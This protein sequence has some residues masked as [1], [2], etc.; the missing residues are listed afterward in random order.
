[1]SESTPP[2][3]PP[4]RRRVRWRKVVLWGLVLVLSLGAGVLGFAYAY[5]TDGEGLALLIRAEAPRYLPGAL[6]EVGQ[7][8]L[9]P[10]LGEVTLE[11]VRLKQK[12][13][14]G[15]VVST[16]QV[17]WLSV[18]HDLAALTRGELVPREVV[19]VKPVLRLCRRPDGRWNLDGLLADPW[20][21]PPLESTPALHVRDGTIELLENPGDA[22]PAMVLRDVSLHAKPGTA[23]EPIAVE[24]TARGGP[25]EQVRFEGTF[26]LEN[27]RVVLDR[28]DLTRLVL[29]ENLIRC[30]PDDAM[31]EAVRG[32]GLSGGELD[33]TLDH[34]TYDPK[35]RDP[36][37]YAAEVRLRGGTLQ[38][39]D[40]PFALSGVE[41]VAAIRDDTVR[42]L[43]AEARYGKTLFSASG[44]A[45][46]LDPK[47]GPLDLTLTATNLELDER[48][49]A[50]TPAEYR[51]LWDEYRP[52][53]TVDAAARV[54]RRDPGGPIGF[55]ASVNLRDVGIVYAKFQY[56]LQHIRGTLVWEGPT[57][58]LDVETIVGGEPLTGKGT[59]RDPGDDAVV[60]I[61]FHAGSMPVD[62]ALISAMPP[63]VAQV[64]R[65]FEPQ[66]SVR[67]VVHIQR[68]PP[69]SPE[70]HPKADPDGIYMHAELDLNPGSSVRWIG[71][72]Y[73]V[74]SVTGHLDLKPDRWAFQGMKG[75][76]GT[77]TLEADGEVIVV[78][79]DVEP[80]VNLRIKA[81]RLMFDQQLRDALPPEWQQ[82][83]AT[84]NPYGRCRVEASI[85]TGP[86][87]LPHYRMTVVPE[88]TETRVKLVLTPVLIG[89]DGEPTM[90]TLI[91]LPV[92]EN[93]SGTFTF[94]DGTVTMADVK[95]V[96]REAPVSC[97]RGTVVLHDTGAFELEVTDL[98][99]T[100][101][102][103]DSELRKIM[104]PVMAEFAQRLDDGRTLWFRGDMQ[105][106]WSG[107]A[108]EPATCSWQNGV[109]VF[110]GNS[111]QT[112]LPLESLQ[113]EVRAIDGWSD[114]QDISVT[115]FVDLASIRLQGQQVTQLRSP[116]VVDAGWARFH[117]IQGEVL[118]GRVLGQVAVSL[119]A[120]PRFEAQ[121][122][123][124]GA[125]LA[126][127]TM[128]LPGK[129]GIQGRLDSRIDLAGEG[130]DLRTITG[131]GWARVADGDLGKLPMALRW[132]KVASFRPPT[133]TAFDSAEVQLSLDGGQAV[134]NSIKFT[135]DAF[136][137]I[138]SGTVSL[139][140]DRELNLRLQPLYGRS[141]RPLPVVGPAM[142]EAT[143]RVVDIRVTGPLS[144][145]K[146][147]PEPLPDVLTRAS[148]AIRRL[149]DRDSAEPGRPSPW[150]WSRD[151]REPA[152]PLFRSLVPAPT[153]PPAP[154]PFP[155]LPPPG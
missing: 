51:P 43:S 83:W 106:G 82:T 125:D 49:K 152:P 90:G 113:G 89:P 63:D 68:R 145:P 9:R 144:S 149:S 111:I 10:F 107:R 24:G 96:F 146:I 19:L 98:L 132:T 62:E 143:G 80:D 154:V 5:V 127:T 139:L 78:G 31:R 115:G 109:V 69:D 40:L 26:D 129:S 32:V 137:L 116:V 76:N 66:G 110:N 36:L 4:T 45:S 84:L 93:V 70:V 153:P 101:L 140:G 33:L 133:K 13:A 46:A 75:R 14:D 61:D 11:R 122:E 136:S 60:D 91:E 29:N 64:V 34:L 23:G 59:I 114:G 3:P 48:L 123:L 81:D 150:P 22:A 15:A 7:V 148:G 105:I 71:M 99:V 104:P 42:V 138:G 72:P 155:P 21:A 74:D 17:D 54:V 41:V 87:H 1:M 102:R 44:T 67:G 38:R 141:E 126:R 130:N 20:P 6:L 86:D 39:D 131:S 118:G 112:E 18:K 88:P 103:L 47:A 92:M 65:E 53:G 94:D 2:E 120:T 27:G 108:G 57:I 12:L 124:D 50:I 100:K 35:A 134:L 16:A 85:A 58:A 55:G 142:R 121:I 52:S 117:D 97:D 95:C 79:P 73:L 37:R 151:R 25:F 119:D 8:K 147:D 30:L 77:A 56:P 135:G 128:T 28:G